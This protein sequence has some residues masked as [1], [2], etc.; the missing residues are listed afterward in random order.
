MKTSNMILTLLMKVKVDMKVQG[1]A[2]LLESTM[3]AL[4]MEIMLRSVPLKCHLMR[5]NLLPF[6]IFPR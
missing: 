1:G 6:L 2:D 5:M 3:I 4:A